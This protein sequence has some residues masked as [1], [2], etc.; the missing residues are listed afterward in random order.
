MQKMNSHNNFYFFTASLVL[1]LLVSAFVSS[2][3]DGENK[4]VLWLVILVT[5][6]V[7]FFSLNLSP[8]WRKFVGLMFVL[9]ILG[10]AVREFTEWSSASLVGLLVCLIFFSGMA[11]AAARQVL[12]TGGVELNTI[13]GTIAVYL[14]LALIWTVLYLIA[15]EFWPTAIN[16]IQYRD[17]RDNFG[18]VAYYSYIT[19]TTVG[20]GEITPAIPVTRT[21]AYLQAIT[22]TFYMA[23][24]VASMVG[25]FSRKLK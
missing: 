12:V 14:L 9:L 19:M 11:F 16:G 6:V 22:G 8:P 21:L 4:L 1:L 13:V 24:V 2:T 18:E 23:I 20:Y 25:G 15:L 17:W 5:E 7:A 10:Q 3:P